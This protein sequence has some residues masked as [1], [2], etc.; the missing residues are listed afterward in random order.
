MIADEQTQRIQQQGSI[1]QNLFDSWLSYLIGFQGHCT[2]DW[3][4]GKSTISASPLSAMVVISV[5][6]NIFFAASRVLPETTT[7]STRR[8]LFIPGGSEKGWDNCGIEWI[9]TLLIPR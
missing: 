4:S 6:G 5:C 9:G 3:I 2:Q 1:E 8:I 7:S